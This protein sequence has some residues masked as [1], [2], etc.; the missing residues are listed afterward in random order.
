[1]DR[2]PGFLLE[3]YFARWEFRAPYHLTASDAETMAVGELLDVAGP[4]ARAEFLALPLGYLPTWG[5]DG[6]RAAVA[7]QYA[8]VDASGV[9]AFAGAEEAMFWALQELLGPGDH[10]VV[11]VPNY[12]ALESIPLATGADVTG[13]PLWSGSGSGLRWVL[14]VDRVRAALRPQ[15]RLVAV[16]FP[17]NP[18]GFVPDRQAWLELARLCDQRGVHLFSD[19]VYRGLE[20]DPARTLPPAADLT[21][22]GL[23]L[24]VLSKSFGLPGLRVGWLASR[25]AGLLARLESRKHWTSISNAGPSEFLATIALT[26]AEAVRGR[27]RAIIAEN[28]PL[29]DA[30]FAEFPDLFDWAPPDGG[31]VAFPRYTGPDGVEAFCADLVGGSGV[32][33]LPASLYRSELA[34]VPADRF[35]IGIGRRDP[36]P[37]LDQVRRYL[38]TRRG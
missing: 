34:Q 15:T 33:V 22:R 37:A 19:E 23:S 21:E 6:L 10:A 24:D 8:A 32:L 27:V 31:C 25:D 36:G 2:L 20:P 17:N 12:Q 29:F 5:T 1:M 26:H 13:V 14:D 11:T 9:L 28:T 30:F 18:T 35:R 4:D 3:Q 38:A 7:E 16:N